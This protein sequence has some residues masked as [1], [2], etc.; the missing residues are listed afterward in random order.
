MEN[1]TLPFSFETCLQKIKPGIQTCNELSV[2]WHNPAGHDSLG[3]GDGG[4]GGGERLMEAWDG[5]L[6]DW[7]MLGATL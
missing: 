4:G 1:N 5:M 3:G 6:P 2:P 7:E